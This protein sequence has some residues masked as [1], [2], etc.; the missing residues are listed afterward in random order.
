[1]GDWPASQVNR[2]TVAERPAIGMKGELLHIAARR[3]YEQFACL[4]DGPDADHVAAKCHELI[5]YLLE[6]SPSKRTDLS[7]DST[8]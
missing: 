5:V 1:M 7:S 3:Q 6:L 2:S 8:R 4:G